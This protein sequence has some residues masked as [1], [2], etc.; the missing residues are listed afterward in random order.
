MFLPVVGIPARR[1]QETMAEVAKSRTFDEERP[2]TERL[3]QLTDAQYWAAL[4][5]ML[6]TR[7]HLLVLLDRGR[8]QELRERWA[9]APA[10]LPFLSHGREFLAGVDQPQYTAPHMPQA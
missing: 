2:A 8:M 1:G 9:H 5:E 10:D 4:D 6:D 7:L 3:T